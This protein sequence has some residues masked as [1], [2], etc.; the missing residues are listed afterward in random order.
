MREL[1]LRHIP[2]PVEFRATDTGL[3]ILTGY[4]A[5]FNRYSQNL[6]GFVE[7]VDPGAFT[8]SLGDSVPVVA[9]FNH[10]DNLL[11][12]TTEGGTL[13]LEADGTGLRYDI[14]LPDTSAGRDVRALAERGDLRYSS[15]AFR[16]L[17][18][19]WGF[20]PEGFPLRT[21]LGV[22][23]VDVAPVTNPAY[24]DTTTGLRSLA[25]KFDIGIDEVRKAAENDGLQ[26]LLTEIGS[27]AHGGGQE[28][29]SGQVDNHPLLS[30]RKR[31]LE[32]LSWR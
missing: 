27:R 17:T 14:Q 15:F 32:E 12:G 11:L 3:G 8:K 19:D 9:R 20:T 1:E 30:I 31:Q 18:D 10:E 28:D 7:Q 22:Q 24:R 29:N 5:V 21:L 13:S 16:T 25:D 4:A 26:A 6:G 2:R 23:L